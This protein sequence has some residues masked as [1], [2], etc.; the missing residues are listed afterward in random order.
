M[1]FHNF[2]DFSFVLRCAA[3]CN[4]VL[5]LID[6]TL[7]SG[8]IKSIEF[9]FPPC[10]TSHNIAIMLTEFGRVIRFANEKRKER[11]PTK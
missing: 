6:S 2:A 5:S 11:E 9:V 10:S 8:V 3:L 7:F 1:M 4:D